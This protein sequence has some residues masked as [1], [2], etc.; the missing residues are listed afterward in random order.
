METE[1]Y[2]KFYELIVDEEHFHSEQHEKRIG[3]FAKIVSILFGATVAGVFKAD[4]WY[5]YA[6]LI[7]GPFMIYTISNL[8]I[9]SIFSVYRR[10]I[11]TVSIRAKLEQFLK[12]TKN[13]DSN[14]AEHYWQNESLLP[15]RYLRSRKEFNTSK[16]FIDKYSSLGYQK[17]ASNLFQ[18]AKI[19]SVIM[20]FLLIFLMASELNGKQKDF[21]SPGHSKVQNET[22]AESENILVQKATS[23]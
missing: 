2:F 1:D 12:M 15:E 10:F 19:V 17:L 8:G 4:Q 7:V 22:P 16:E 14:N 20:A 23:F 18:G 3:F 21:N 13:N 5:E 9:K 6:F 11:E